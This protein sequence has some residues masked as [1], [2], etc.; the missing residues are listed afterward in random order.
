MKVLT[1]KEWIFVFTPSIERHFHK[2]YKRES[3][4]IYF[5]ILKETLLFFIKPLV[6]KY[7]FLNL[8]GSTKIDFLFFATENN[9]LDQQ[10]PL[11]RE[12]T[13]RG[14]SVYFLD[15]ISKLSIRIKG[16]TEKAI[17]PEPLNRGL[18]LL[19]KLKT[20]VFYYSIAK[21]ISRDL[22]IP[23]S[24]CLRI[25]LSFSSLGIQFEHLVTAFFSKVTINKGVVLGYDIPLIGRML[26]TIAK[27]YGYKV[28][29]PMHGT[30]SS[31][32]KDFGSAADNL[33]LFGEQDFQTL[34]DWNLDVKLEVT[35][36]AALDKVILG[37]I[38][39][40]FGSRLEVP[41][42]KKLVLVAGS[43]PGDSVSLD[44]HLQFITELM[45]IAAEYQHD[46]YF[47]FKLHIKDN[48][49]YYHK[50][51]KGLSNLLVVS[52]EEANTISTNI[53]EWLKGVD[54]LITGAST[55][56]LE[57]QLQGIP[58]V[59]FDPKEELGSKF[60]IAKGDTLYCTKKDQV[61]LLL[62]KFLKGEALL[63]AN[64][65]KEIERKYFYKADGK[66]AIRMADFLERNTNL[67]CVVSPE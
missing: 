12:L 9:H 13:K 56:G 20:Y 10:E 47:V 36:S 55:V 5:S 7:D 59:S 25:L 4:F 16:I 38:E 43:G 14:N 18:G 46:F 40:V 26:A 11:F 21:E 48:K 17:S 54:I 64:R 52:S 60:Y 41:N 65:V 63:E 1:K 45:E 27:K 33:F 39:P 67:V 57:A 30:L 8:D 6:T 53:F 29:C 31:M 24:V 2:F 44:G 62:A 42:Q 50:I 15:C 61:E 58:C 3:G 34:R 66:S 22:S 51:I 49:S 19:A 28:S 32:Y 23:K 37:S 35:G